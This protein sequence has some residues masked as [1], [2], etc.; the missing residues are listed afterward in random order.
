MHRSRK[1]K[2]LAD[3]LFPIKYGLEESD[4]L[5]IPPNERFLHTDTYDFTVGTIFDYVQTGEI[6]IP[7]YQRSY[8]WNRTQASRFIESLV[9]QCP[10]P[11]I[12][13]NQEKNETWS[14]IDGNQRIQSVFLFLEDEYSLR[15]LRTYPELNGEYFSDLDP[16]IQ[17]HITH[18]TLRC[19]SISKNTH[20][21][22]KF[23]VFERLNTGAVKLNPQELRHG[24]YHGKLVELIDS[25]VDE[26]IWKRICQIKSDTRMK[27]A[28][29]ILRFIAF[30]NDLESYKKPLSGFL[31]NFCEKFQNPTDE[32]LL[33]SKNS[34]L[35]TIQR[36]NTVLG[37][38]AFRLISESG[39]IN[40]TINAA[41]FDAQ[42]IGFF[43]FDNYK[44]LAQNIDRDHLKTELIKL[45]NEDEF[46]QSITSG[47]SASKSVN[48]RLKRFSEFLNN[49]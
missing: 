19:I 8:V 22:I 17:R 10:I 31:N 23:D 28:E 32:F 30:K 1:T 35:S 21:Q 4:I 45:Y 48:Y 25:M 37:D 5:D 43:Q 15:G 33:E 13:L 6:F 14:V 39:K 24:I 7:R 20:P 49:L 34:F 3:E 41:L 9:I 40:K 27:S 18:R 16:R 46:K 47:T 26:P 36:V 38:Y 12:Y 11:I 2:S 42:M 29:L 44:Q